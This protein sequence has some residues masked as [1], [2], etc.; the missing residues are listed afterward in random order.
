[1][2]QISKEL[3]FSAH[4]VSYWMDVHK[5]RKRS[6]SDAVY[7]FHNPNGDPF[8]LKEP[9]TAEEWK[10]LGLG[11]GLYWGEGSKASNHGVRLGNTDP[12]LINTFIEYLIKLC[13]VKFEALKFGLQIF[14]DIDP[15]V[16]LN[17][18]I[19]QVRAQRS[20]FYKVTVS[21]SGKLGTYRKKSSYGVLTVYFNNKRLRD[22][23]VGMLPT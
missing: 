13:G 8:K 17:Y 12:T 18:W 16:A 3:G 4:K 14:T 23:L 2:L 7:N 6:I 1:M 11:M 20:Q 21:L 22:I 9:I 5:I 15:E 10:L 19:Y